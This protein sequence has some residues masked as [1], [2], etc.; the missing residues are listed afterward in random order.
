[1]KVGF[2]ILSHRSPSRIFIDLIKFFESNKFVYVIHHDFSQSNFEIPL[3]S[4][5]G[6]VVEKPL[7]TSWA[8]TTIV[9]ATFLTIKELYEFQNPDW[10]VL[11]SAQDYPIKSASDIKQFF[12]DTEYDV[13]MDYSVLKKE[14]SGIIKRK[15]KSLFRT[16]LFSAPFISR[17]LKCYKKHFRIYLPFRNKPLNKDYKTCFGSQWFCLNRKSVNYLLSKKS[18][19]NEINHFIE[20]VNS[21]PG[22]KVAADEISLHT[23]LVNSH[24]SI[25]KDNLRFIDWSNSVDYHPNY[26]TIDHYE[27]IRKSN[28]IFAR[29]FSDTHSGSL[30][31]KLNSH[32]LL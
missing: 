9:D 8:G 1:M 31:D 17:R 19:I 6:R 18:E 23:V 29:K 10:I 13:F 25:C 20:R 14:S 5:F 7:K 22:V 4:R 16:Y 2:A 11:I 26:L 30:C 15:W 12:G 27:A 21:K 24:L 28:A 32:V 3:N